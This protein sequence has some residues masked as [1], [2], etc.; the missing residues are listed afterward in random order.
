MCL[1]TNEQDVANRSC[2]ENND[3]EREKKLL[4]RLPHSWVNRLFHILDL[5]PHPPALAPQPSQA[6]TG[7]N[8]VTQHEPT[9]SGPIANFLTYKL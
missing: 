6:I 5:L 7:I 8:G 4:S 2:N 1:L 9:A 3:A